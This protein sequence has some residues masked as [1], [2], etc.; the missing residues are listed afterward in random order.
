MLFIAVDQNLNGGKL[1]VL[2]KTLDCSENEARG[3]LINLWIWGSTPCFVP[4]LPYPVC[5]GFPTVLLL[6]KHGVILHRN[7]IPLLPVVN[8]KPLFSCLYPVQRYDAALSAVKTNLP[9]IQRLKA[10]Q[11]EPTACETC[12][13]CR[14]TKVLSGP[15]WEHEIIFDI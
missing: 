12:E 15:I 6:V 8:V 7:L 1:R 3:I 10:K 9:R 2:A 14:R 4:V 13:Y 5:I 11:E